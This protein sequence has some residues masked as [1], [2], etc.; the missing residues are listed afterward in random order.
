LDRFLKGKKNVF[1]QFIV[2]VNDGNATMM[3]RHLTFLKPKTNSIY[4]QQQQQYKK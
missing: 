4:C 1:A 3:E 2:R